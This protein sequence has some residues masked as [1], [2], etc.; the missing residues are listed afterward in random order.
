M[1]AM[2]ITIYISTADALTKA[3][4][5]PAFEGHTLAMNL[6]PSHKPLNDVKAI[7]KHRDQQ[8]NTS[9][10]RLQISSTM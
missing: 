8:L 7:S 5:R 3:L 10:R 2:N 1:Q 6:Y 9:I 4:P